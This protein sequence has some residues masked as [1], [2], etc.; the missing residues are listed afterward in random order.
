MKNSKSPPFGWQVKTEPC[1]GFSVD[2]KKGTFKKTDPNKTTLFQ[3]RPTGSKGKWMRQVIVGEVP[4]DLQLLA[5][6][7][8]EKEMD[9]RAQREAAKKKLRRKS[10][11]IDK[12]R[13]EKL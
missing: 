8:H 2:I 4:T 1:E 10:D 3:Y 7:L 5:D 6:T 11:K 13:S 9:Q 12:L